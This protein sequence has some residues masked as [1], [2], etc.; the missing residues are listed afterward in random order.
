MAKKTAD[1]TKLPEL[2]TR[3]VKTLN[4]PEGGTVPA[5]YVNNVSVEI[6]NWDVRMR[7]GQIQS[8]TDE[9][10]KVQDIAY[11]FMS[12]SHFKAFANAL[13]ETVVKLEEVE[14]RAREQEAATTH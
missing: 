8:A 10:V 5:L 3:T 6:S 2:K 4:P 11:V 9:E 12:H 14:Q 1:E 7:M 13:K